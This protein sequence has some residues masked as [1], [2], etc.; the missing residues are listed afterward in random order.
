MPIPPA[1]EAHLAGLSESPWPDA[2][3]EWIHTGVTDLGGLHGACPC[4]QAIRYEHHVRNAFTD[5]RTSVGSTCIEALAGTGVVGCDRLGEDAKH[6]LAQLARDK[7][8]RACRACKYM[9]PVATGTVVALGSAERDV[10]YCCLCSRDWVRCEHTRPA[11]KTR[12]Q[13]RAARKPEKGLLIPASRCMPGGSREPRL[14]CATCAKAR[15]VKKCSACGNFMLDKP[16]EW[17]KTCYPCW[18]S[19][20]SQTA[21]N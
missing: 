20:T 8:H 14:V 1:L 7:T 18:K 5:A 12:P 10:F 17:K 15:H 19:L 13:P 21:G 2:A 9:R 3:G 6:A 11:P 4:G 16:E